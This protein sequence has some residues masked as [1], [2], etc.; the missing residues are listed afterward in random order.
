MVLTPEISTSEFIAVDSTS[1][2]FA[3]VMEPDEIWR[4]VGTV[5]SYIKQGASDV[6]A[7]AGSLSMYVG[8]NEVV[9]ISGGFAQGAY[10]A[11][12]RAVGDG[13]ATLTRM[14]QETDPGSTV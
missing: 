2:A 3:I 9:F 10:L 14:R 13:T 5:A 4:Y 7:T 8:P 6:V 11:T 1:T 12:L